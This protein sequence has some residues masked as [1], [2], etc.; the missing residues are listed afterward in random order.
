VV[1]ALYKNS[2]T[3]AAYVFVRAATWLQQAKL[4]ASDAAAG[5]FFGNSVA[6]SG[7]T[8]VVGAMNKNNQAGAAYVFVRSG[9]TWTQQAKLTASDGITGDEFGS[10]VA[11]SGSIAVVGAPGKVNFVGAA[12]AF[13]RSGTTWLQRAKVGATDT[14]GADDFGASVAV[15]SRPAGTIAVVGAPTKAANTGAAYVFSTA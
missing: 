14:V 1:G 6:F 9:T 8:A 12:Y 15:F 3:G 7:S 5:D 10:S 11:L 13:V 2:Q 4:T